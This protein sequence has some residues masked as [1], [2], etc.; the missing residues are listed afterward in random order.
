MST[1]QDDMVFE[2]NVIDYVWYDEPPRRSIHQACMRGLMAK[3][4]ICWFT[5]TPLSEP[6]IYD[7]VYRPGM[8][9]SDL[10]EVFNGSTYDNEFLPQKEIDTFAQS[11]TE[12]ERQARLYGKFQHLTGRVIKEY[13]PERHLIPSFDIPSHWPV[14]VGIDPHRNKPNS[15]I[16]LAT[17]PDGRF[18]ICNEI[19]LNGTIYEFGDHLREIASQY[20][21]VDYLIDT[22]SQEE[23]WN[24]MS[25]REMLNQK[26]IRTRLAQKKGMKSSGLI[27]INQL[28]KDDKLFVMEHCKRTQRELL[29]YVYKRNKQDNQVVLEEPEKKWDDLIDPLRYILVER[30]SYGGKA[31]IKRN[32]I[33]IL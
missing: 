30:P 19:F 6:W 15:A 8:E 20:N 14:W 11:L 29:N 10:I 4:G 18:Y 13:S 7:E 21:I 1:E 5:C 2:G 25:A 32:K 27:L 17:A 3:S 26:G 23:G 16:F 24:K 31:E 9:G 33:S 12:D 28:F 22:S